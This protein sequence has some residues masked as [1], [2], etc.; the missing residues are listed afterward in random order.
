[1]SYYRLG[2]YDKAVDAVKDSIRRDKSFPLPYYV[3]ALAYNKL[4]RFGDA[5]DVM[6]RAIEID[7][8]YQGNRDKKIADIRDRLYTAKGEEEADLKDYLEIMNY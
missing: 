8:A 6:D 1:M 4:E 7:P 3:M 2:E 5:A